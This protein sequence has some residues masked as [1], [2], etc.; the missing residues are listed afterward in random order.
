MSKGSQATV[1]LSDMEYRVVKPLGDG[2]GS[3]VFQISDKTGG[4]YALKVVK[5]QDADDEIY[6]AQALQSPRSAR[7][8]T[9]RA[10][11]DLRPS[12]Q[13]VVVQVAGVELL[14]EYVDGKTLDEL[15]APEMGQ[16][17]LI[18]DQVASAL[19]PHAPP[20]GLPRRPEA[21][22]HHAVEGRPGQADR[23]RHRLDPRRGEE[24]RPG[25][26]AVHG[27]RAG[28][29]EGRRRARPT[30]TTSARRCTACSPAAT[31]TQGIPQDAATAAPGKL[32]PPIQ[33]NPKIPGHAQRDDPG[34]PRP[35]PRPRPASVFE[36]KNQLAAVAK[37]IGPRRSTT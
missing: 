17:V 32:R 21:V 10:D 5:R 13:E 33:I 18:F 4:N 20:G 25:D 34:L 36:V 22:E 15:E 8:S 7:S 11:E 19:Q 29:R 16:L 2:A 3:T 9:T 23:L 1:K 35:E 14:M 27:P 31:S 37:Y 6:I 28:P 12:R 30:S 24:P 26:A